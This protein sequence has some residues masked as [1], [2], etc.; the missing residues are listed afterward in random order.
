MEGFFM[1]DYKLDIYDDELLLFFILLTYMWDA[2]YNK[3]SLL[4]FLLILL[5]YTY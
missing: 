3:H 4:L 5:M 2:K 1:D